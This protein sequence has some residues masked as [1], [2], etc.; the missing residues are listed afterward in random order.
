MYLESL[1]ML[2]VSIIRTHC[3]GLESMRH[4][5]YKVTANVRASWEKQKSYE[6][7]IID[8]LMDRAY[9]AIYKAL[10]RN[11]KSQ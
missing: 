3:A 9:E 1:K 4:K 10:R 8:N 2:H 11:K 5:P 6:R 7:L